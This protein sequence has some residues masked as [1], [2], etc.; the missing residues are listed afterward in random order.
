MK[1]KELKA[2]FQKAYPDGAT[3][4]HGYE[5]DTKAE[6]VILILIAAYIRRFHK[7]SATYMKILTGFTSNYL[8]RT[9]GEYGPT[10]RL[11]WELS[12]FFEDGAQPHNVNQIIAI[13]DLYFKNAETVIHSESALIVL[14]VAL[15]IL[16]RN[17][18]LWC[19]ILAKNHVF[20]T[21]KYPCQVEVCDAA[22]YMTHFHC[23]FVYAFRGNPLCKDE[24]Y[25]LLAEAVSGIYHFTERYLGTIWDASVMGSE[26]SYAKDAIWPLVIEIAGI[27][28]LK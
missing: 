14:Y 13:I 23:L 27:T 25:Y 26:N 19:S 18:S 10:A 16:Y 5:K 17:P 2:L 21:N 22:S 4:V 8:N 9:C 1:R 20:K 11:W 3:Y 6:K 7:A 24:T 12:L 15:S 28:N